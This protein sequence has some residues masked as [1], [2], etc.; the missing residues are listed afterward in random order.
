MG[1]FRSAGAWLVALSLTWTI[2]PITA[3]P[4]RERPPKVAPV[5]GTTWSGT[6]SDGAH[7]VFT[8]EPGGMLSYTSPSGSFRSGTWTQT[9]T[10]VSFEMNNHYSDYQ[11]EIRGDVMTGRAWNVNGHRWTWNVAREK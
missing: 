1:R 9:E 10:S 2:A 3:A 4:L 7:Y 5:A 11:G 6:D 8:F